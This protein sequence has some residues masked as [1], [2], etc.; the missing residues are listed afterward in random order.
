MTTKMVFHGSDI[1]KICDYYHLNKEDIVKFGANVNPLGLSASVKKEIAE[2]VDLF[3]L[4]RTEIMYLSEIR[5]QNTAGFPLNLFYREM[6]P[7]N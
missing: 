7:V 6:V 2:N 4:I 5:S 1:E 3:L